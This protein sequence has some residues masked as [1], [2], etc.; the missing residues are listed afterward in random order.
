MVE[1]RNLV[2]IM[3]PHSQAPARTKRTAHS[4]RI[5]GVRKPLIVPAY[6]LVLPVCASADWRA[7][8]KRLYRLGRSVLMRNS[9]NNNAE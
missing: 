4:T 7:K 6:F 1:K 9:C 2:R 5:K 3:G 8:N